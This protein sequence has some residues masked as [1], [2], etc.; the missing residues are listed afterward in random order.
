MAELSFG[1][2]S[3]QTVKIWGKKMMKQALGQTLFFKKFLGKDE[4]A[5]I[6]WATD[7]EKDHGDNIKYDLLLELEGDGVS[8]SNE[9][10]GNEENLQFEQDNIS[11]D[12]KRQATG[13]DL[14]ASQ[15][16]IHDLR[17]AGMWALSRWWARLF[18]KYMWRSLCGDITF[19][20]AN[21]GTIY[22]SNHVIYGGTATTEAGLTTN[23][24]FTLPMI[25]Y[26][27][28]NAKTQE[29]R[30]MP[31]MVEG[32][33]HYVLTLHPYSMTDLKLNVGGATSAKWLEI[34]RD[35]NVR[36][37][38][39]PIFTGAAG[40]HNNVIIFETPDIFTPSDNVHR[41]M[42]LGARAGCFAMGNAY[43]KMDQKKMG[44]DNFINW[45]EYTRDAG[46]KRFIKAGSVFGIKKTVFE[47][48][49]YGCI[50]MPCYTKKSS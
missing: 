38:K 22:D 6:Y 14:M 42:F 34:Q 21:Q 28:E 3:P 44:N 2:N 26:A 20:F 32:K 7:L 12:Q 16:S 8:G 11:I 33:Q 1:T 5:L 48:E 31:V 35:A 49:D 47:S 45:Y 40:I 10:E 25:D 43:D 36:G 23:D 18:E 13:R 30:M 4:N 15:R 50:T 37:S 27:I 46:D 24:R 29:K 17:Q 19:N 39:N 9:L 41:N